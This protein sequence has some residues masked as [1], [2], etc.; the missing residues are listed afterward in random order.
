MYCSGSV[1]GHARPHSQ[2]AK[3]RRLNSVPH[4]NKV[5]GKAEGKTGNHQK[6]FPSVDCILKMTAFISSAHSAL[7]NKYYFEQ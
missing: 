1:N 7:K 6:P 4:Y 3:A 5:V 2:A